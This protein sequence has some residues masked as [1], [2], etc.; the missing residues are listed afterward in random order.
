MTSIPKS[1][2]TTIILEIHNDDSDLFIKL[3]TDSKIPGQMR[4]YKK[5]I[6]IKITDLITKEDIN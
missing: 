4:M 6:N 2:T 3:F 1:K 5:P